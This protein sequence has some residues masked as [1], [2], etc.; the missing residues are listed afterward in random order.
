MDLI[1]PSCAQN[2]VRLMFVHRQMALVQKTVLMAITVI[3]VMILVD[4]QPLMMLL[5]R[6]LLLMLLDRQLLQVA[7]YKHPRL[8][9]LL[10]CKKGLHLTC[11]NQVLLF[12]LKS[13]KSDAY[14]L[15]THSL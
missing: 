2:I 6:R 15:R 13:S 14:Y 1:A 11:T 5:D 7:N 8:I 12:M 9:H 10:L 3:S 4:I